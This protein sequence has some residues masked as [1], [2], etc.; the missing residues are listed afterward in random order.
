M[1]KLLSGICLLWSIYTPL[2]AQTTEEVLWTANYSS[3]KLSAIFEEIQKEEPIR[4]FFK[5]EWI[6]NI[7]FTGTFSQTPLEQV[8]IQLL[9]GTE[10]TYQIYQQQYV[11]LLQKN[12]NALNNALRARG[13]EEGLIII[14]DSLSNQGQKNATLSGYVRDGA[15]GQG[16][17]GATVFVQDIQQGT[18]T[19]LNGYFTLSLPVGI[20]PL[21]INSLG[22]EEEKRNIRMI[23]DGT[24]SVDLYEGT[25][26]LEEITITDRAEDYNVSSPQMSATR[27]DIQKVQKMPAFLGEVDLINSIEMLPGVSVA[28]EGAAGFNVRGGDVGQNLILLDGISIFNPSHLFGFF[29][30]FNADLLKDATLYK[31]GIPARYGGRIAS[32]LDVSLKEGNLKKVTGSGGIGLVASRLALEIPLVEE[33]SSLMIGGRASYSDWILKRVDDLTIRQSEASFYDANVKWTYRLNESHKVGLTGYI[34]HDDFLYAGNTSYGYQNIGAAFNWDFLI[35]QQW[36]S[37]VTLTHSRFTYEVGDLQDST[38]ASLLNAG[39]A[40]SEGRWNLTRFLGERHQI[41]AGI[42]MARYGFEPGELQPDGDFSLI[43]P[44]SLDKEQAWDMSLYFNDEFTITRNLT[45]NLGLRYNHYLA[46]GPRT[47]AIYEEGIPISPGSVVDSAY[48][49]SGET[50]SQYQ[51]FEPRVALRI[52]LDARSSVKLSYNRMRQNMHLISNTTS[53][54][55]TD[56]WKLSD[57]YVRPQ[58]GDQYAIGYFRNAIGNAIESSIEVYYKDIQNLVEYKDGA[59]ILMND[60]LETDLLTGIGKAYGVEMFLAK[61]LGRLTGWLSYT[62]SRS[63]RQVEGQYA[64][65]RI[66]QGD[67]YPSNFDKPHD[68]TVVGNYQFTRRIRLGFNFTYS[69]GRPI[70]LPEGTYR[71]G[72]QDIAHFSSRNQYRVADYH[73]LDISISVDG[74]LKKKKKWDSS[75]T[76]ALYNLY[77]RNN[78]YSVFFRNDAGGSLNAYQLSILGRPFPSV[79]YNFKF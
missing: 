7:L 55:P 77:G 10:L 74:N 14:G 35:S 5:Q 23:S 22:F 73:R 70:S 78:P 44:E 2:A 79:T 71:V 48:Y 29:S 72:N 27:M 15:T 47:I 67:W 28:G 30:A 34:S 56:I 64:D 33:K 21:T 65:E 42:N 63:L 20:H 53:I 38:R 66:N 12:P 13:E 3:A 59:E 37:T 49:G 69:T 16:V 51:G 11:V 4:F 62:Y 60:Q 45:L 46:V 50:V 76:F 19:N 8:V 6:E 17:T 18:S 52:G 32:V 58:I 43:V 61:N 68:F 36:L 9:A 40:I 24:L 26:R 54:T 57:R 39:F 1:R 75:W 41:D 25:A 31:G